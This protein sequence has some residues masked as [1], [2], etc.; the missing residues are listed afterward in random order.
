[1]I[2]CSPQGS[3]LASFTNEFKV[4]LVGVVAAALLAAFILRTDDRPD[5]A[6]EGYDLIARFPSASGV[7]VS[8][9]VRIAGV[10]IGSVR[11]I[12]LEGGEAVVT[13]EMSSAVQLPT[14]SVAE[15]KLDGIL[16]DRTVSI[17]PGEGDTL[18]G[19]GDTIPTR[20]SGP[21]TDRLTA[22][23][24]AIASNVEVI[25][26]ELRAV[27]EKGE[28]TDSLAATLKNVEA[29]SR[30]LS[31][32]SSANR[33]E[34]DA[35]TRNLRQLSESL[36]AMVTSTGGRLDGELE[37][38]GG[39]LEKLDSA[40][41][42]VDSIAAKVDNGEGTLGALVNDDAPMAQLGDAFTEIN[43]SLDEVTALVSSVNGLSVEASYRGHYF[44]GTDP[45]G[46]ENPVAGGVRSRL[47]LTVKPRDE[48]Y[49]VLE[50][51]DYPAGV[52][53]FEEHYNPD[54]DTAWR[55][56]TRS[57]SLRYSLQLAG[58]WRSTA[59]RLGLFESS[60]GVG[61]DR[62]L[63]RDRVV[64]TAEIYDFTYGSWPYYDG[65]PNLTLG[66]RARPLPFLYLEGGLHNALLGARYDFITGYAGVGL[67]LSDEDIKGLLSDM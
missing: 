67:Q 58:R 53:T 52:L 5:G 62:Y 46:G 17:V 43:A 54:L 34:I 48:L 10:S 64:L 26:A 50:L 12:R 9:Q 3:D 37:T 45:E 35:I 59:L 21:D 51:V 47:G 57:L 33:A 22:Q 63:L 32:V 19:E 40:L 29:L 11:A 14:D 65:T 25:T 23:A 8:T 6:I 2:P 7:Y 49:Y 20:V 39:A 56:Y 55:Q 30:D 44:M 36:N 15:L 1:V 60:G 61:I 18:L 28:L 16:G 38:L 66:L 41:A 4:G 24:E 42:R 13:L 31:Q 27:L